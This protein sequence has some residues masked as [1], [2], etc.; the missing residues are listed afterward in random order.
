M[1]HFYR[2]ESQLYRDDKSRNL[3]QKM[4]KLCTLNQRGL[5]NEKLRKKAF[6]FC[7]ILLDENN[8]NIDSIAFKFGILCLSIITN[9]MHGFFLRYIIVAHV[10][11]VNSFF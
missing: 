11:K 8:K 9:P 10:N 7:I 3:R 1:C 5:K 2:V 6:K 4:T